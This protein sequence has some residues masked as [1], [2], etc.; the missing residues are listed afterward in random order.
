MNCAPDDLKD[1]FFGEIDVKERKRVEEHLA[2][3]I[4]C[5]TEYDRLL[6]T[7]TALLSVREEELPRRIAFV[8][9]K[10]FEPRWYRKLWNS[11]P[12]LG[13]A[14]AAMLSCA[15]LIHALVPAPAIQQTASIKPD[16]AMIQEVVQAEVNRRVAMEVKRVAAEYEARGEA[17]L[18]RA[19]VEQRKQFDFDRRADMIALEANYTVLQKKLNTW[20]LASSE[21]PGGGQ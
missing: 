17:K 14:G 21:V 7:Q 10:V 2:T 4:A 9:D 19:M 12:K 15:I 5:Q 8:S 18:Q 11:G 20:R 1:L 6:L 13:F 3:C 16:A